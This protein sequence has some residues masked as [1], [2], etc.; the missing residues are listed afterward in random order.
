MDIL[1]LIVIIIFFVIVLFFFGSILYAFLFGKG[2]ITT[3]NLLSILQQKKGGDIRT[4]IAGR[5]ML[6]ISNA[7][8]KIFVGYW[9]QRDVGEQIVM[10]YFTVRWLPAQPSDLPDF[11]LREKKPLTGKFAVKGFQQCMFT[12]DFSD[13]TFMIFV[14]PSLPER[15]QTKLNQRIAASL[16][17]LAS[18]TTIVEI[19]HLKKALSC[20]YR[21]AIM[22]VDQ[23][24][25]LMYKTLDFFQRI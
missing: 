10:P 14:K 16:P 4:I 23:A 7:T 1:T 18:A 3:D 8:G 25:Q 22:N 12:L 24:E 9:K 5:K 21:E 17:L 13:K 19:D 6:E 15:E 11:I 2:D 20:R